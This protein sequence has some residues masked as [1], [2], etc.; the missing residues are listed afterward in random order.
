MSPDELTGRTFSHYTV[1][2]RIGAGGMGVV[3]HAH[4]QTLNRDVVL[5]FLPDETIGDADAR[6]RL[7]EEGRKAAALNHPGICTIHEVGESEGRVYVA[8]E[9][10]EGRPLTERT[11]PH[12]LPVET[13][14]A[15]GIQIAGAVAHAHDRG[16]AHRDLKSANVIVTPEGRAKVL[17]FGIARRLDPVTQSTLAGSTEAGIGGIAGTWHYLPPEALR[18]ERA[19]ARGDVWALGILLHEMLTGELPFRGNT[20][21]ELGAAIL[22]ADPAPLPASVPA[23]LRSVIQRCLVKDPAARFQRASEVRAVLET[24]H[25]TGPGPAGPASNVAGPRR[26]DGR[27][28]MITVGSVV[29]VAVV[30]IV[31]GLALRGRASR[32]RTIRSLA[33]LPL[34]NLSGDREQEYFADG[35]TDELITSL[36]GLSDVRVISRTSAMRYRGT[37]KSIPMIARELGV[38]AVVEG[39]ALRAG[40][41]VRIT[42][43]L[44]DGATDRHLWARSYE[45]DLVNVLALQG[46]V[47]QA[48]AAEIRASI[49]PLARDRLT[50]PRAVD[51]VAYELYLRGRYLWNRRSPGALRESIRMFQRAIARDSTYAAAHAG[52]ADAWAIM[53]PYVNLPPRDTYP[54]ARE[55]AL[56]A[57]ALDGGLAQAHATLGMV[58]YS[59]DYDWVGA[60]SEFQRAFALDPGCASAH[61]Y[62]SSYLVVLGRL[63]EAIHEA[64]IARRLD[65]LS[66]IIRLNRARIDQY[67][68][69][70]DKALAG[71]REIVELDPT[72]GNGHFWRGRCYGAKGMYLEWVAEQ[73][74]ADSLEGAPR[75]YTDALRAAVNAAG[76]RGFWAKRLELELAQADTSYVAPSVLAE[77][78]AQRGELERSFQSLQR[79]IGEHD[80]Y[81]MYLLR[82]WGLAPLRSHPRYAAL[83][84]E[85][86]LSP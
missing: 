58:K 64:D 36:A 14:F 5:K 10:I 40:N 81:W 78:Y 18:G 4:D 34:E 15:L 47:A 28:L 71:Y 74:V 82:D 63:D 38:D 72:F 67:A 65:P 61:Q 1:L 30:L 6:R 11:R 41:Q 32:P 16:I 80:P 85:T 3:H 70:Y 53:G 21:F 27:R 20:E 66:L 13:V 79:A 43:Q 51:P 49:R 86:G 57:L 9:W 62:R 55:E 17:D 60:E 12:G 24:V 29:L 56:R 54:H 39:T 44:I 23:G 33:V 76:K 84:R 75:R 31:A 45:R 2:E 52:L 7:L 42:A 83:M 25:G 73:A 77:C 8:M 22:G 19:D 50:H 26:S 48:I 69:R 35:M 37:T 46:E 68:G 59:Y